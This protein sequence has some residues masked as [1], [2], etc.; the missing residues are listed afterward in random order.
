MEPL[1]LHA[2]VHLVGHHDLYFEFAVGDGHVLALQVSHATFSAGEVARKALSKPGD[3]TIV[4]DRVQLPNPVPIGWKASEIERRL[5]W[6]PDSVDAAT[7]ATAPLVSLRVPLLAAVVEGLR[8]PDAAAPNVSVVIA[9]AGDRRLDA[10]SR[11]PST[12]SIGNALVMLLQRTCLQKNFSVSHHHFDTPKVTNFDELPGFV[13]EIAGELASRRREVVEKR[14][15]EWTKHFRVSLSVNTGPTPL[16]AGLVRGLEEFSPHLM[17]V[18][19]PR[20]WPERDGKDLRFV[21]TP[22][23]ADHLRQQPAVPAEKYQNDEAVWPAIEGMRDW[24]KIYIEARPTRAAELAEDDEKLFWFRK[25]KQEVLAVVV[26]RDPES[27]SLLTFRGVNLEV[28]LPTGT[29]CAERNAIGSALV[30][31]PTMER[32]DIQA[33]AVLGLKDGSP[34]LGPCGACTEWLKKMAE[35]N[36]D[37]R[38]ITFKEAECKNVFVDPVG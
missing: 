27:C 17:V 9:S 13:R 11:G 38:V 8:A 16:I 36:P 12:E 32:S 20:I 23:D 4:G 37:L 33:V 18:P 1:D 15:G 21:A 28:S 34:R 22:L 31:L 25:G 30:A 26:V 7:L 2:I 6:R 24:R 14:R 35:A 19:D 3:L 29:L 10:P 5:S